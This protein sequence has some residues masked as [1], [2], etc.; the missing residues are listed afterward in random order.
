MGTMVRTVSIKRW[1][2]SAA[3]RLTAYLMT[4]YLTIGAFFYFRQAALL[5]RAPKTFDKKTPADSGLRFEDLRIAVNTG[6]HLIV[7]SGC[8]SNR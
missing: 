8:G 2:R 4:G 3:I 1:L 6:D 7:D 5:F